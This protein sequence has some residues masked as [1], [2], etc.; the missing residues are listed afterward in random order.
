MFTYYYV[1]VHRSLDDLEGRFAT[2]FTRFNS[3]AEAAYRDGEELRASISVGAGP[4]SMAKTVR[5]QVG[6]PVRSA[7]ETTVPIVWEA[8]GPSGM[9]PKMRGK[10]T[11][12]AIG[13][14]LTQL[15]FRG[16]YEPPLGAIGRALDKVVMHRI[17]E[18]SVKG[19]VDRIGMA[20]ESD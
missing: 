18:S 9:F 20:L 12:A 17:A 10:L 7:E 13:P 15:A 16:D 6:D 14:D 5:M 1:Q 2:F 8:T 19:F 4:A 3:W 11:L